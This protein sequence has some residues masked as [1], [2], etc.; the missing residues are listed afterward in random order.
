MKLKEYEDVLVRIKKDDWYVEDLL[1]DLLCAMNKHL[2][3]VR[4]P[5]E[6]RYYEFR[7]LAVETRPFLFTYSGL[8]NAE[9]TKPLIERR[10]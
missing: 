10:Y 1:D 3:E 2:Y 6:E 8:H 7:E 5:K 9:I 4:K